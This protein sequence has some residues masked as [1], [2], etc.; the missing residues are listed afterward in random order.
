M[1]PEETKS[2]MEAWKL[3]SGFGVLGL[4]GFI[5]LAPLAF[6][7]FRVAF[8]LPRHVEGLAGKA[9]VVLDT[10]I[11]Q[12]PVLLDSMAENTKATVALADAVA[13][14]R[15]TTASLMSNLQPHSDH[16]FSKAHTEE[17]LLCVCGMIDVIV[18]KEADDEIR[19]AITTLNRKMSEIL[20]RKIGSRA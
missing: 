1:T 18:V 17:A 7:I 3:L 19:H 6:V 11:A 16:P 9:K 10:A 4:V 14:A 13:K 8:A 12:Q 5:F 15:E 20:P 2:A